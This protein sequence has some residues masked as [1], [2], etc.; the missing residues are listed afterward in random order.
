VA[1]IK[2]YDIILGQTWLKQI[3]PMIDWKQKTLFIKKGRLQPIILTA[4]DDKML[5]KVVTRQF[6]IE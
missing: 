1:P 3:N 6:L 2:N 4:N 5:W